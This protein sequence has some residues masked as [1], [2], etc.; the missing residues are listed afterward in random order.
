MVRPLLERIGG[1]ANLRLVV[2]DLIVY[3]TTDDATKHHFVYADID[4]LKSLM[5]AH[6]CVV[7]GGPCKYEGRS[8][9]DAHADVGVSG[10]DYANAVDALEQALEK[11][12]V[13]ETERSELIELVRQ[14]GSSVVSE[15]KL[16]IGSR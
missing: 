2:D 15:P 12:G 10:A 9:A 13:A 5:V 8:M 6:L 11:H 7:A 1:I 4:R 16:P 14:D 3:M